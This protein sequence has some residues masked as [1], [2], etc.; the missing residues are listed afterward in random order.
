ML[1]ELPHSTADSREKIPCTFIS[2]TKLSGQT[3]GRNAALIFCAEVNRPKPYGQKKRRTMHHGPNRNGCLTVALS[4]L[5]CVA[6]FEFV[7]LPASALRA[8]KSIREALC[9]H[10]FA[11]ILLSRKPRPKRL[12]CDPFCFCRLE[13]PRSLELLLFYA[14]TCPKITFDPVFW[15]YLVVA[16][17]S[18]YPY[19]LFSK[20]MNISPS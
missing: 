15:E 16:D 17:Q 10:I 3:F 11:A 19:T 5:T 18:R 1:N 20:R 12:E 2:Q 7:I 6:G 14:S 4:A 13:A 8:D 9:E